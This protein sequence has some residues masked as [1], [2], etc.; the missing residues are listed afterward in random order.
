MSIDDNS[1]GATI[2]SISI[3]TTTLSIMAVDI[4]M[5]SVE[6]KPI[7]LNVVMLSVVVP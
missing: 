4:V 5:L 3:K 6:N 1:S 2:L 7:L